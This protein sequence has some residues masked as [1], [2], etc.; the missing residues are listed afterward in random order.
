MPLDGPVVDLPH[1]DKLLHFASYLGLSLLFERGF[2]RHYKWKGLLGLIA[3]SALIE[4]VQGQTAYRSASLAD[5]VANSTG[6]LSYL[7]LQPWVYK[8]SA[9][10]Q[11]SEPHS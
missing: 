11:I 1:F 3:Y 5:L 6:A 4:L 10:A 8:L 9:T 2:P 7:L